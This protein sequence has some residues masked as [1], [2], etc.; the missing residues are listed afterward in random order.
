MG[1]RDGACFFV[2]LMAA[3][4]HPPP[5]PPLFPPASAIGSL[6]TAADLTAAIPSLTAPHSETSSRSH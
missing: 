1:A 4:S 3:Q 5:P 2:F 6:S